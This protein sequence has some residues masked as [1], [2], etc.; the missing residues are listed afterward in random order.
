MSEQKRTL[1]FINLI[2]TSFSSSLLATAMVVALPHIAADLNVSLS[3]GQW[4]TS[5]FALASA[6]VMPLSAYLIT[7]IPTKRLYMGGLVLIIIG[8]SICAAAQTFSAMIAGR[9]IQAVSGGILG[10]MSQVILLTIYPRDKHG[11]IMG[12]YGMAMG[13]G[14]VIAP[15]ISGILMD[16]HSWRLVFM[17]T[18]ALMV[19][20][21]IFALLTFDNFLTTTSAKFDVPSFTLSAFAFGGITLGFGNITNYGIAEP[22]SFVP[23]LI[24]LVTIVVFIK[25]QL[26]MNTPFLRVQLLKNRTFALAVISVMLHSFVMQGSAIL[27]PTLVQTVYH[28][29]ATQTG[30][31][32]L[33][34]AIV[35]AAVSPVAGKIYDKLGIRVLYM[36]SSVL[37]FLSSFA[38]AI[39][40]EEMPIILVMLIYA[41][42]NG[43]LAMLM[44][45]F[46]TWGMSTVSKE[47]YAQGTAV[48]NTFKNVSGAIGSA[49]V[50]GF[51]GVVT[52]LT[53]AS[54]H[55]LMYGFNG[56]FAFVG[57]FTIFMMVIAFFFVK[58]GKNN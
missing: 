37:L 56:A 46:I 32:M 22:F 16:L 39:A 31:F 52:Q 49:V 14:P 28:Y 43:A 38:M 17:V 35:F 54:P 1:I 47:L 30:L 40:T 50:V 45:P 55:A 57:V 13:F 7:R 3:T 6:I 21:L 20:S 26:S 9:V 18:V 2:I 15:T 19:L 12:W 42:R 11:T 58:Q 27:T 25:R 5:G 34:P 10:A 41:L 53:A 48:L 23:L 44:M 8:L 24:G 4:V 36:L 33:I 51:M 29:S